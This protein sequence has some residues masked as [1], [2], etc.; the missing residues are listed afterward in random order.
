MGVAYKYFNIY[1]CYDIPVRIR[2]HILWKCADGILTFF[3]M[4]L[5]PLKSQNIEKNLI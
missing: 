3:I 2:E 4:T 1:I 5:W